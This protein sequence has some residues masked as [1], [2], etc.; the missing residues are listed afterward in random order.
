MPEQRSVASR[1]DPPPFEE[2]WHGEV[3]ALTL[4][5]SERAHF[6]W[7][8][9]TERFST[10]LRAAADAGGPRDGSDYYDVWLATLED[11]L[12]TSDIATARELENVK[13]AWREAYRMT[14]HGQPV[15]LP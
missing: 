10:N 2:P 1:T 9:W 8:E 12:S 6:S 13:N 7:V 4:A 3:F 11:I 15:Q 5:L 14:P